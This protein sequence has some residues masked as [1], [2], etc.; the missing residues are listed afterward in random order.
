MK[1]MLIFPYVG[2]DVSIDEPPLGILYLASVLRQET[3]VKVV[4]AH[5]DRLRPQALMGPI[6]DMQPDI[7]GISCNTLQ[8]TETYSI[9]RTIK[10]RYPHIKVVVGGPHP[11]IKAEEMLQ[12]CEEI[13][14]AVVGEGEATIKALVRCIQEG[15]PLSEVPGLV[16]RDTGRLVATPKREFIGDLD[17]VPFPSH[18]MNEPL[19]RYKLFPIV[20]VLPSRGCPFHCLYCSNPVWGRSNRRRSAKNI[21]DEVEFL[22]NTYGVR[23]IDFHDDIFN[24]NPKDVLSLCDELINRGLNKKVAWACE[25]RVNRKLVSKELLDKMREAGCRLISFGIESG[26]Q[27]ILENIRKKITLEEVE[28]AVS[29]T[30]E[31][32]IAVRGFFMIGNWGED[33]STVFDTIRFSKKL[34]VDAAQFTIATPF[35]GS[36]YYEIIKG[37]GT[38]LNEDYARY[39][40]RE[41]HI[42]TEW[43]SR[44]QLFALKNLAD[45]ES[46]LNGNNLDIF[47]LLLDRPDKKR[48]FLESAMKVIKRFFETKY[49][50]SSLIYL[51][52]FRLS[53]S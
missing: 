38:I 13:D 35:P 17:E 32:G 33:V 49:R 43:L 44:K 36:D 34:G 10:E 31:A 15:S 24:L 22:V 7:I 52:K 45:F 25:A 21:A 48:I 28:R 8:V 4:D 19:T 6:S 30:K 23:G 42:E 50:L 2:E 5:V 37:Q 3:E 26:N 29:L 46:L 9:A 53:R 1:T 39:T 51:L 47:S 12:A 20:G 14:I 18:D 16:Y 27:K 11:S 41:A 40:E